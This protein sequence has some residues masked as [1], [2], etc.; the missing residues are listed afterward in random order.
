MKVLSVVNTRKIG[1]WTYNLLSNGMVHVNNHKTN[2]KSIV[3]P[4]MPIELITKKGD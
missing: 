3:A 4:Q 2:N 1:N